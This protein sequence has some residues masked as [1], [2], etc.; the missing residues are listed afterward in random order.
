MLS[1]DM[2]FYVSYQPFHDWKWEIFQ[3][4]IE[5][6][7]NEWQFLL[8]IDLNKLS[9]KIPDSYP[10]LLSMPPNWFLKL[11]Q[12][13]LKVC[14]LKHAVFNFPRLNTLL[15]WFKEQWTTKLHIATHS[16]PHFRLQERMGMIKPRKLVS[17]N[18]DSL[19][20][21]AKSPHTRKNV[22]NSVTTPQ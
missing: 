8:S 11:K 18:R 13:T 5:V 7:Q 14:V 4:V 3:T 12:V 17:W 20:G 21:K 1:S 9:L 22:R 16:L 10:V 15:L 6:H 19:I 2:Y